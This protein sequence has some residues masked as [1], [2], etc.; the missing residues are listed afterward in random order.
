MKGWNTNTADVLRLTKVSRL[1]CKRVY[2]TRNREEVSDTQRQL[3]GFTQRYGKTIDVK[4]IVRGRYWLPE[5][6]KGPQAI[7]RNVGVDKARNVP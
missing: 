4:A 7:S 2:A 3:W 6:A 5:G 1:E